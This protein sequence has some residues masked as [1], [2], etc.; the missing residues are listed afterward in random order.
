MVTKL[1]TADTESVLH[2]FTV[3]DGVDAMAGLVRDKEGNLYGTTHGGGLLNFFGVGWGVV[4]KL[5]TTGTDTVLHS[6]T[7]LDG[8]LP[9]GDLVGGQEGNL[10]RAHLA[11]GSSQFHPLVH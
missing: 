6:F 10:C 11:P 8:A 4:F 2:R 1:D 7:G 3:T 5:D 9:S